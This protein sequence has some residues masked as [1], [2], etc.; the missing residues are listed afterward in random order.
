MISVPTAR[1]Q[2]DKAGKAIVAEVTFLLAHGLLHLLG[3]D[4]RDAGELR[5]MMA[6]TEGLV[7][8]ARLPEPVDKSR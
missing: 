7:A 8:A 5:R 2:A 6:L 4:H 3:F 1:R